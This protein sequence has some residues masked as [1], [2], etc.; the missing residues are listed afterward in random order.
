MTGFRW[1]VALEAERPAWYTHSKDDVRG[2]LATNLVELRKEE[3][4]TQT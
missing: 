3:S 4:L 1:N 2:A